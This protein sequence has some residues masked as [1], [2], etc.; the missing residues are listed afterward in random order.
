MTTADDKETDTLS[1]RSTYVISKYAI[2][3]EPSNATF[4]IEKQPSNA[5]R[6]FNDQTGVLKPKPVNKT[7]M[8]GGSIMTEDDSDSDTS[9]RKPNT[10]KTKKGPKELFK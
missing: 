8:S 2:T 4:N 10:M 1:P 9:I 7:K 5:K 3:S 6:T